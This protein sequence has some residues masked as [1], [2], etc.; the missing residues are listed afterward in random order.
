MKYK[1]SKNKM[2]NEKLNEI[3]ERIK[4]LKSESILLLNEIKNNSFNRNKNSQKL[5]LIGK[6]IKKY[7]KILKKAKKECDLNHV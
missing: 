6:E 1:N 4:E 3:L 7:K 2:S 5:S